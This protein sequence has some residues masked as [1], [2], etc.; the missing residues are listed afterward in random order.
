MH[1]FI[2]P[3][4]LVL[5]FIFQK[6]QR[7][8]QFW[9]LFFQWIMPS[10]KLIYRFYRQKSTAECKKEIYSTACMTTATVLSN[11]S[12]ENSLEEELQKFMFHVL[13]SYLDCSVLSVKSN[14]LL[15]S[16]LTKGCGFST[17]N[18]HVDCSC[19]IL[20]MQ[21]VWFMT[22]VFMFC[23]RIP[24]FNGR[25]LSIQLLFP[26]ISQIEIFYQASQKKKKI[27]WICAKKI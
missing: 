23:I 24:K 26:E 12:S 9:S 4:P 3:P 10:G 6:C 13:L 16:L 17:N 7:I 19:F 27:R 2:S 25:N 21:L 11:A 18:P 1:L 22:F 20:N 15:R 14:K 5:L 8:W